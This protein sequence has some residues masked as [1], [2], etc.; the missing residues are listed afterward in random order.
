MEAVGYRCCCCCCCRLLSCSSP[1]REKVLADP[2]PLPAGKRGMRKDLR[3]RPNQDT[4]SRRPITKM[5]AAH[6]FSRSRARDVFASIMRT[7]AGT[8][9][10]TILE[11]GHQNGVMFGYPGAGSNAVNG[12]NSTAN[13][14]QQ[15][16]NGMQNTGMQQQ[17]LP[18]VGAVP[19]LTLD[20]MTPER[21]AQ[22]GIMG[23]P[24]PTNLYPA[25]I[26]RRRCLSLTTPRRLP[27][28][29]QGR[30]STRSLRRCCVRSSSP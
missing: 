16:Q 13:G 3:R 29:R 9:N 19:G 14:Q 11:Q 10:V 23:T 4:W 7:L 30:R 6:L 5:V 15:Q 25:W 12:G 28:R 17:Q 1:P 24:S 18:M 27:P 20:Q 8:G 2:E 26:T 21:P 22:P